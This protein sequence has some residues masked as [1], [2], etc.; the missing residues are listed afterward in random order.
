MKRYFIGAVLGAVATFA[1]V[2]LLWPYVSAW[3]AGR[4]Y[5]AIPIGD[6]EARCDA[7]S[8]AADAWAA[9][10]S[11]ERSRE[12][13]EKGGLDCALVAFYRGLDRRR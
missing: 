2:L 10:G 8:R 6:R 4:L 7:A 9:A 12:W 1:A 13:E 5:E 3:N 11:Y